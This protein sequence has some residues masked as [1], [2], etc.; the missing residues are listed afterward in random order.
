MQA[1]GPFFNFVC[2]LNLLTNIFV[3]FL[4]ALCLRDYN[5]FTRYHENKAENQSKFPSVVLC[6]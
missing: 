3:L 1:I 5:W 4:S 2:V 6:V